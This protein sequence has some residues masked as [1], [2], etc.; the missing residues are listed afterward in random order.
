M[1]TA[2]ELTNEMI[3]DRIVCGTNNP[4]VK[5]K[6]L[7]LDAPDLAKALT[8]ARGIEISTTQMK[9]LNEQ[10]KSVHG[11]RKSKHDRN[12]ARTDQPRDDKARVSVET[13]Q[14]CPARGKVCFKCKKPNINSRMCR[15]K[16]VHDLQQEVNEPELEDND[17]FIGAINHE[18]GDEL[19][20][21]NLVVEDSHTVKVKLDTGAQVNVMPLK[22]Y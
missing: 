2:R 8:I 19:L 17:F 5:E 9:Y 14:K 7:Q 11:M 22:W 13:V 15:S 12:Q 21:A 4:Q 6:L 3:R 20:V 16:D 10:D 18:G 1:R